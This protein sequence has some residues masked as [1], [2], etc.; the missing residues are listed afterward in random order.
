MFFL[1]SSN[2]NLK[3]LNFA[4]HSQ[5]PTMNNSNSGKSYCDSQNEFRVPLVHLLFIF[6]LPG[7][8]HSTKKSETHKSMYRTGANHRLQ[9]L[10]GNLLPTWPMWHCE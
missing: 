5:Q 4:Y 8:V 7:K 6:H 3:W 1:G 10:S 2:A 9:F